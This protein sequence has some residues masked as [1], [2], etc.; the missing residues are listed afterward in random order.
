LHDPKD[1]SDDRARTEQCE[2]DN[3]SDHQNRENDKDDCHDL[4]GVSFLSRFCV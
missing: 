4:H 3:E 2:L 1:A